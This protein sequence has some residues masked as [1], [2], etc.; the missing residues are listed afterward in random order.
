MNNNSNDD[1]NDTEY[2][3]SLDA[4]IKTSDGRTLTA[5]D[6]IADAEERLAETVAGQQDWA[7]EDLAI[8][9]EA[10]TAAANDPENRAE[11]FE[12]IST[13]AHGLK[14]M[15]TSFGYQLV[16]QVG[17]SLCDYLRE[18]PAGETDV[19]SLHVNSLNTILENGMRG[20]G[21]EAGREILSGLQKVVKKRAPDG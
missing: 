8:M 18:N 7:T 12:T 9:L 14:G 17:A 2:A 10:C 21:E 6:V 15:G 4:S 3:A 16:T 20:D 13:R 1:K 5:E 11:Y 19:V